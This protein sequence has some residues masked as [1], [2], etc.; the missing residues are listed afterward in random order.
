MNAPLYFYD[1]EASGLSTASFPIEVGWARLASDADVI[2]SGAVLI[3][4]VPHWTEWSPDAEQIH[5]ISRDDLEREGRA[6]S[7]VGDIL[8]EQFRDG[9]VL[10]DAP[11][12]D[13]R[14]INALY[15]ELGRQRHWRIGSAIAVLRAMAETPADLHWLSQHLDEPRPHRAE[16]DAR[17]LAQACLQLRRQRQLRAQQ[18]RAT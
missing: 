15:D 18:P 9:V 5:G 7:D 14:W 4:P 11:V 10:S 1:V 16:A 8:D 13:S 6:L 3:R 17:L 2:V 12:W